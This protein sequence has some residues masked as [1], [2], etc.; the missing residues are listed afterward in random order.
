MNLETIE[1]LI[2]FLEEACQDDA[3][4]RVIDRGDAN[5]MMRRDGVPEDDSPLFSETLDQDLA[6]Y[7][8]AVL[9]A[10]LALKALDRT[11]PSCQLGF[12][13]AGRAFEALVRNGDPERA[14]RGFHRIVAAAAYHLA[15]YAAMAFALLRP[16]R[17]GELN[18]SIA[19]TAIEYL[20]LRD[21][22]ALREQ[23]RTWLT[24]AA[25]GDG[26]FALAL[27][28]E[29]ADPDDIYGRILNSV[30]CRALAYFDLALLS[31]DATLIETARRILDAGQSAARLTGVVTLWWMIRITRWLL[32]DLWE[33][34]L[35]EVLPRQPEGE[36]AASY[37]DNR[38]I[39]ISSLIWRDVSQIDLWPSQIEAAR[40]A[41]DPQDDLVVAMQ[42]SAGKTRIAELCA[43]TA[44]S[45]NK[46]VLIV[47]PLRALSAQTERSFREVFAPLGVTVSSLYGKSGLSAGDASALHSDRIVVTTPEKLDFAL[48]ST[49]DVIDDVG[50]IVLDEG[51][52]IG[53]SERELRFEILVQR[54]L[55]REDANTRR[56]VCL[57]AILPEGKML[58]DMTSWLRSDEPGQACR[59]EWR[60]TRQRFG[61]LEWR[62]SL[63]RLKYDLD[64]DGPFLSRFLE[65]L[66]AI[67]P[68]KKAYPRDV[69]DISLMAA[70][71]F[72][73]QG[74]RTLIFIPTARWVEGYASRAIH[75]VERG[76]LPGLLDDQEA[77]ADAVRIGSEWLGPNHPAVVCLNHGIAVHQG[78]LP[79]PFLREV[80][81]LLSKG[82]IKVTAASPTLAQGLNLN[83][84]VLLAPYLRR[85]GDLLTGEEF[86]NIAGRAGRAFVDVEGLILHVM[87]DKY[88]RRRNEWRDLR[89][90]VRARQ[91]KSGLRLI[92]NAIIRRLAD[93]GVNRNAAAYEYLANARE[94]WLQE[95]DGEIE[96]EPLS[97]LVEKLDT[98]VLGLIE[99]FD[100]DAEDLPEKLDEVLSGS[101]W[102]HQLARLDP[103]VRRMH[104]IVLNARARLIWSQSTPAQRRGFFAMGV[105]LESGLVIEDIANDLVVALSRADD[106]ALTGDLDD[107]HGN[108][109][110]LAERLLVIRPFAPETDLPPNWRQTL[111]RWLSGQVAESF[112]DDEI[113]LIEDAFVYRLVWAIESLRT[114][115]MALGWVPDPLEGEFPGLAAACLDTGLPNFRMAIL[116]RSGLASR[117][118]AK[119]VVDETDPDFMD[120]GTLREWL[121]RAETVAR[122]ENENW[123]TPETHRLWLRFID[124]ALSDRASAWEKEE[125]TDR[126]I[127]CTDLGERYVG[128]ARVIVAPDGNV[129]Y[130]T[131]DYIE[132]GLSE[133]VKLN[134]KDGLIFA[135]FDGPEGRAHLTRLGPKA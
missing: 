48:R 121:R 46:R 7:G 98:I 53:P 3:R 55:R 128:S 74:K 130:L 28:S 27:R 84:A 106:G 18:L 97:V 87:K 124:E 49:P 44:L 134:R 12:R 19:E 58:E 105:G 132:L 78:K 69:K 104:K 32:D 11:H 133:D 102:A 116:V 38:E 36:V 22:V 68:E 8:F 120:G 94:P 123:P 14:D 42:T 88:V 39:F 17:D 35:H 131:A 127:D 100:A 33:A 40:R 20:V 16:Y 6:E 93:A 66:P 37:A 21:F 80:E 75:L 63:A 47:T 107:L 109:V 2:D 61:T 64:D 45:M 72:A 56:I 62:G 83:A 126:S 89:D 79:S 25:N 51:H 31:G 114:R 99:A 57:S 71:R 112:T 96:G 118:A 103:G 30:V 86:A 115:R 5:S 101:L 26:T 15:G 91:L 4:A 81:R 52:I 1:E 50:L 82:V 110:V 90:A 76:Y 9:D 113:K 34:S 77:V 122:A 125:A 54:L 24:N 117:Q 111:R 129:T 67:H 135:L 60:P 10:A 29:D 73:E 70:W 59:S 108:L 43:L 13:T 92:I 119:V 95:P 41:A 85:N 23:T 65:E